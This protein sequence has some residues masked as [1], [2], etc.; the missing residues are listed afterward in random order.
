MKNISFLLTSTIAVL[1]L[2]ASIREVSAETSVRKAEEFKSRQLIAQS[3]RNINVRTNGQSRTFN[4]G[5]GAIVCGYRFRFQSDGNLVLI[6]SSGQVLWAT[7]TEGRGEI[8]RLQPDGNLVIYG[9]GRALWATNTDGNP[10]AFF[11]IQA[12]GNL[13]M[14]RSNGQ[15]ALW[16][17][18]TDSGQ[19]RTRNAAGEWGDGGQ[20]Q[21]QVS[22]PSQNSSQPIAPLTSLST[23][24]TC[25]FGTGCQGGG[26]QHT[27]VDYFMDAGS[28]VRSIC[29][30]VVDYSSTNS[31]NLNTIWNSFVIIRHNNCG[32]YQ[33]LYAYYGHLNSQVSAGQNVQRGQ[34]IGNIQDQG[35]NSHLHFG[36]ATVKFNN[37]WGYQNG[38]LNAKGWI[39]PGDFA[40]KY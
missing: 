40:R 37:G 7:G 33:T 39:D 9:G 17:S 1:S 5:T 12:D 28:N 23:I 24:P 32:G 13:V 21:V 18:N 8:L 34:T 30:G 19:F 20:S 15:Q 4:R 27:G 26:S 6:N 22:Q 31:A 38:N 25:L 2:T 29:D 35:G 11:A 3:C 16:A 14:Y 10:G 36:L